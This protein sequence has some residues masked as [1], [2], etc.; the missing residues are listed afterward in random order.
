[1][2]TTTLRL[3]EPLRERIVRLAGE[4]N[5]TP[6][7]FMVEAL[8]QKADE[9]EWRLGVQREAQQRDTAFQAGEPGIEWHE[10]KA[11]LRARLSGR[12]G[13]AAKA[14]AKVAAKVVKKAKRQ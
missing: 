3:E 10:M 6:H 4:L 12:V 14:T 13:Q 1:M 2:S 9:A 11:Y 5:Q 7:S 8:A